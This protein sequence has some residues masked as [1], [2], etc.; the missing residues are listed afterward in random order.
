MIR[1][2]IFA[3]GMAIFALWSVNSIAA[4]IDNT[5]KFQYGIKAMHSTGDSEWTI[6]FDD[7][8]DGDIDGASTPFLGS[9]TNT[10]PDF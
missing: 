1:K 6:V 10:P 7:D 9:H 8:G 5:G 2:L 4:E 3:I